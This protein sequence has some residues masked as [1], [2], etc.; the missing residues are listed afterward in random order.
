MDGSGCERD[1]GRSGSDRMTRA[2]V[3][4]LEAETLAENT[5]VPAARVTH[6]SAE[7]GSENSLTP[8]TRITSQVIEAG[9]ENAALPP[10]R[11]SSQVV[12]VLTLPPPPMWE[13]QTAD[14]LLDTYDPNRFVTGEA[15]VTRP[16]TTYEIYLDGDTANITSLEMV[17]CGLTYEFVNS[18]IDQ[19][20]ALGVTSGMLDLS[21]DNA[22]PGDLQKVKCQQL[23]QAGWTVDFNGKSTAGAPTSTTVLVAETVQVSFDDGLVDAQN[24]YAVDGT[25]GVDG[26]FT[27]ADGKTVTV[28]KGIITA[29]TGP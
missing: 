11:I 18:I 10:V 22:T 3:T 4:H 8:P 16:E 7:A 24:G 2:R 28:Q 23:H 5:I 27:T 17:D 13:A 25:L 26:S 1:A 21:G 14:T 15:L 6:V 9:V 12:E 29:V 20:K 19:L